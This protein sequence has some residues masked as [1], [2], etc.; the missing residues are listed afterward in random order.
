MRLLEAVRLAFQSLFANKLKS[1]FSL[2][3]VFIG[4]T[5]LIAVV[6]IVEGMNRYTEAGPGTPGEVVSGTLVLDGTR[7]VGTTV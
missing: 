1:G 3:G 2:V 4:V 6:S 5:F 7:F